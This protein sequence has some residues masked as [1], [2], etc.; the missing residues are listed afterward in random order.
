MSKNSISEVNS[1]MPG[2]TE[3]AK[4]KM[5]KSKSLPSQEVVGD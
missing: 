5:Q 4:V 2:D 1:R 3:N